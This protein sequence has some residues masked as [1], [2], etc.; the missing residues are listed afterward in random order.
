MTLIYHITTQDALVPYQ[1]TLLARQIGEY[2]TESLAKD[3]FIHL[4]QL[5]QVLDVANAFYAGQ[6][7][8]VI[9]VVDTS[10]LKAELRYEAPVH[11][12][13]SG[14]VEMAKNEDSSLDKSLSNGNDLKGT[15]SSVEQLFPHLYG[16]LNFDAVVKAVD[17]PPLADGKFEM[18]FELSDEK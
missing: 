18:P 10:R 16:P 4:S 8:L 2:R 5:H 12:S 3:G 14:S 6:K 17:L 13:T 9:L 1:G 7:D 15:D 11:P